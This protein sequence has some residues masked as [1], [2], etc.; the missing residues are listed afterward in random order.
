VNAVVFPRRLLDQ[1]LWRLVR[2]ATRRV[3]LPIG[4]QKGAD[5]EFIVSTRN[6]A[7]HL[8]VTC[9]AHEP[10]AS[11]RLDD[12]SHQ[13]VLRVGIGALNGY[14]WGHV[15]S[16]DRT[17][18]PLHVLRLVGP[19]MHRI[20]LG[21]PGSRHTYQNSAHIDF[22][23]SPERSRTIGA[24]GHDVWERLTGLRYSIIGCGRS[25][26]F[27]AIELTRLGVND[28]TLIDPDIVETHNLGEMA[29]VEAAD[30]G[31]LKAK[32]VA[33][34][35]TRARPATLVRTINQSITHR[36][37]LCAVKES[38][39]VFTFVDHDSARFA[40]SIIATLY[41]RPLIDVATGIHGHGDRR[42]MG[43]DVR[44]TLPG[45]CLLCLGG[46]HDERNAQRILSSAH[47]ETVFYANRQ[48]QQERTGSLASLNHVAVSMG[49]RMLEDLIAERIQDSTWL[50]LEF[51]PSG[52]LVTSYPETSQGDADEPCPICGQISGLGD[53]GLP[54]ARQLIAEGCED[55]FGSD[56]PTEIKG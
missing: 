9:V 13:A 20:M 36:H 8:L 35:I 40:A 24:L 37:S 42:R 27:L 23:Y 47:E 56:A 26:S 54:L 38:D 17:H 46:L 11:Q 29:G 3:R 32:A 34:A 2:A 7:R 21:K 1:T 39:F 53:D 41:C 55:D 52:R 33:E 50:H 10:N 4:C 48:W 18:Q 16:Q 19:G 49:I 28:L 14:A 5:L 31:R 43:A 22:E 25:G 6:C 15:E 12:E 44:L 30:I 45:R 51:L